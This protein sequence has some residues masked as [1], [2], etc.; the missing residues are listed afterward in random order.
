MANRKLSRP[1]V[2]QRFTFTPAPTGSVKV[3]RL[4][5]P[6]RFTGKDPAGVLDFATKVRGE[7]LAVSL[8][9]KD[10]KPPVTCVA[11]I[12]NASVRLAKGAKRPPVLVNLV[13]ESAEVEPIQA[14]LEG[15][16]RAARAQLLELD[17]SL[18]L[19]QENLP[20]MGEDDDEEQP[21]AGASSSSASTLPGPGSGRRRRPK[22]SSPAPAT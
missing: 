14:V 7:D 17:V 11:R 6:L 1:F 5:L 10:G 18:Q 15:A 12:E 13:V 20:G 2:A 22:G 21:A 16:V 3:H 8:D 9:L 19:I 4:R